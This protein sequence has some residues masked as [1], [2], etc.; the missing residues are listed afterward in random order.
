MKLDRTKLNVIGI[1]RMKIY[2]DVIGINTEINA[3]RY[4]V[5]TEKAKR[6][7]KVYD[8][9]SGTYIKLSTLKFEKLIADLDKID[10]VKYGISINKDRTKA[11]LDIVLPRATYGTLHNC[12]N[13]L[14]K[15]TIL[16]TLEC[17]IEELKD[18]GIELN[19]PEEWEVF[20]LEVNKTIIADRP[21]ESYKDSLIWLLDNA[22][23]RG[24]AKQSNILK[25]RL[26]DNTVS[27]TM[28][29]GTN[30]IG[31][32]IY[33][34]TS[35]IKDTLG[36]IIKEN[37]IRLELTYNKEAIQKSFGGTYLKNVLDK[38]KVE[39][40]YN[41]LTKELNKYL[42]EFTD[43][44]I[45]YL[46]SQFKKANFKEIDRVYKENAK[47][48]FDIYFLIEAIEK[49]YKDMG[50]RNFNR[51]IKKLLKNYD[52]SLYGKYN[53]LHKI[54]IAFNDDSIEFGRFDTIDTKYFKE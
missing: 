12:Y 38:E 47:G 11:V 53:K 7:Y 10:N 46:E 45:K 44:E 2:V 18:E 13:V 16:E 14:D 36:I 42:K 17:V 5:V 39:K 3:D 1:D 34:K 40:S 21:L 51:D 8:Y 23:N 43:E 31:K 33:D 48:I 37:L 27:T 20:S 32:K 30:R 29:F 24:Y 6:Y 9:A 28:Y 35:Q 19:A 22:F 54:L 41:K 49:V 52:S 50:N 26:K 25:E 15:T 4:S